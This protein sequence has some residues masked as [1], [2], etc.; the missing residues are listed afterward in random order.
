MGQYVRMLG[1]GPSIGKYLAD[2]IAD[3]TGL[4]DQPAI[5][6]FFTTIP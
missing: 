5:Q 4:F 2:E 6:L 3:D 1:Y